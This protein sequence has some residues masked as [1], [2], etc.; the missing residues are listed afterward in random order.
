MLL[1]CVESKFCCSI[2]LGGSCTRR[3]A[4]V[5]VV[6]VSAS[7]ARPT[8]AITINSLV[9][10]ADRGF[11]SFSLSLSLETRGRRLTRRADKLPGYLHFS[12]VADYQ[13]VGLERALRE[14]PEILDSAL[15]CPIYG[16][17]RNLIARVG[18]SRSEGVEGRKG[19]PVISVSR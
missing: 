5:L 11:L 18:P 2:A 19:L 10:R 3:A 4:R 12:E 15:P 13:S 17:S 6:R 8:I 7:L 16:V 1:V 9:H 14:R